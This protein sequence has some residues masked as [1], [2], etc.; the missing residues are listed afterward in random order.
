MEKLEW[1]GYLTVKKLLRICSAVSTE[2][3]RV[4][5]GRTDRE[6]DVLYS[7][8]Y[9]TCRAVNKCQ[10]K[11]NYTQITADWWFGCTFIWCWKN[12][13]ANQERAEPSRSQKMNNF[14][15]SCAV[16]LVKGL[17]IHHQDWADAVRK[18]TDSRNEHL[19]LWL[20][21]TDGQRKVM[22]DEECVQ[23]GRCKGLTC[24]SVLIIIIILYIK[25]AHS[26]SKVV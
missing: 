18:E 17:F 20:M 9:A 3:R 25:T 16:Y 7:P 26:L 12:F 11:Q 21:K 23:Q 10:E 24:Y 13:Y 4:T 6:T 5:D 22:A 1:W 2:Y 14:L 15:I 19:W 8:R